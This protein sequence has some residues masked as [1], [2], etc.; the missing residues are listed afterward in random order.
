MEQYVHLLIPSEPEFFPDLG[1]IA[2]YFE[3]LENSWRYRINWSDKYISGIR[4]IWPSGKPETVVDEKT[5]RQFTQM[6]RFNKIVV[7][8]IA[9]LPEELRSVPSCYISV[10]GAW[11]AGHS[12]FKEG[13]DR[14]FGAEK[15]VSC[16]LSCGI[17]PVPV[18][19]SEW[20]GEDGESPGELSFGDPD[21]PIQP[22][23]LYTHPVS[24]RTVRVPGSGRAR[25]WLG[26]DFAEW[27]IPRVPDDLDLLDPRFIGA[28][29]EHFGVRF[30]QAGRGI[31]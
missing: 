5:G 29:N 23:G 16:G 7:K 21:S 8:R 26:F 30:I 20:W 10:I 15:D 31:G 11:A 19:T 17:S 22:D 25:F 4:I 2:S 1:Q 9:D 12:P 3:L 14:L 6:P 13:G 27:L 24:R 18:C 28:V